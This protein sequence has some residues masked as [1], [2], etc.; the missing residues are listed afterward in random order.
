M[1]NE[2]W[3]AVAQRD[4]FDIVPRDALRPTRAERFQRRFLSRKARRVVFGGNLKR[5]ARVAIGALIFSENTLEK[6][7]RPPDCTMH[8]RDFN[9]IYADG[10][11][12]DDL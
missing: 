2:S 11:N 1:Q 5:A 7:R 8:A 4:D 3:R 12:H 10:N 9:Q 6:S